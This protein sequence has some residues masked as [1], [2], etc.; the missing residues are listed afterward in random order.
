MSDQAKRILSET[1]KSYRARNLYTEQ[2]VARIVKLLRQGELSIKSKLMK[3]SELES[4]TPGQ[5]VFR[6]RLQGLQ[7][8]IAR[9]LRKVQKD[10]ELLIM[11]AT[12]TSYLS[13]MENGIR[14][15]KHARI[16]PWDQFDLEDQERLTKKVLSVMDRNAL[17]FMVGFSIQLVGNVS[18]ELINGIQQGI[19]LGLINGDSIAVISRGLGSIITNPETF[20]RA[21]KTVFNT[22]QQ[23]LEL[24][25]RTET[26]RAH[27]QGRLKFFDTA[28]IIKATWM[29]VGD[30]RTCPICGELDGKT[31]S[32]ERFPPI[33]A[34]P[35]CRCTMIAY[36]S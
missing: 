31:Y 9:T 33:P 1:L 25:T 6:S 2:Q 21:G 35:A 14:E 13:G 20:R 7:N 5:K 15:L 11:T 18:K 22:A 4:L 19:T 28:K 29:A 27:N 34:H 10:Q 24:I 3:Y 8:D 30:E 32:V 17:D 26:L 23:R 16:P 12:R 36:T